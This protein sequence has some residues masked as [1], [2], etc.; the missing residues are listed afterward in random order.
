MERSIWTKLIRLNNN[1]SSNR[2]KGWLTKQLYT[3]SNNNS[4]LLLQ[5]S[6][7]LLQWDSSTLTPPSEA[8][9][10]LMLRAT[11]TIRIMLSIL[12]SSHRD[13]RNPI[14]DRWLSN[15]S[16]VALG[17]CPVA[18]TAT[19]ASFKAKIPLSSSNRWTQRRTTIRKRLAATHLSPPDTFTPQVTMQRQW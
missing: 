12:T 11:T 19:R 1:P 13:S 3:G 6:N 10:P 8:T 14:Q 9:E 15:S 7:S 16:S 5:L 2:G 4:S 17:A 18:S